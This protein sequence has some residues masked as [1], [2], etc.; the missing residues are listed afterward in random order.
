V[1]LIALF[2]GLNLDWMTKDGVKHLYLN[3][4][5]NKYFIFI[6]LG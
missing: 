5:I 6:Y 1:I 4:V 2:A 3:L